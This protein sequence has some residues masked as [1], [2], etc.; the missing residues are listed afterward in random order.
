MPLRWT[1][2][3]TSKAAKA[4]FLAHGVNV[5]VWPAHS[6]DP[7]PIKYLWGDVKRKLS[8]A[9]PSNGEDLW[10]EIRNTWYSISIK[11]C[12]E[13]VESIPRH[14]AAVIQNCGYTLKY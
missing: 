5:M 8:Q 11:R 2:Q 13:L 10:R 9:N 3:H 12:S 14:C 7:N 4:R 6:P 1:Y